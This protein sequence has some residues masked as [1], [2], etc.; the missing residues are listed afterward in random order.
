[1]RVT[2]NMAEK[3]ISGQRFNMLYAIERDLHIKDG[4]YWKFKCDC[5]E[6][7]S[8]RKYDVIYGKK[9]NCG[10]VNSGPIR[11]F[12][13]IKKD[14]IGRRFTNLLILD[15]AYMKQGNSHWKCICNCGKEIIVARHSLI[16]GNTT[17]C[18]C[19]R[20]YRNKKGEIGLKRLFAQYRDQARK[21]D[22]KF[23]IDINIFKELTSSNCTYCGSPPVSIITIRNN[24]N[25]IIQKYSSYKYNG[26]DRIDSSKGYSLENVTTCCKWCNIAKRDRSVEDFL[27]HI[28]NIFNFSIRNKKYA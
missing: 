12:E 3:D 20:V 9:I 1:M 19:M 27:N 28:E 22:R 5:G 25:K 16:S 11:K 21:K 18:G 24:K 13:I 10:C 23:E 14:M 15:F 8:L 26:L 2:I 7:K 6:I 17:S 4:N